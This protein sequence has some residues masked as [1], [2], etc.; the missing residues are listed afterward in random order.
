MGLGPLEPSRGIPISFEVDAV[1]V[2]SP[3]VPEGLRHVSR[4]EFEFAV[5]SWFR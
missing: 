5:S 4:S 3:E 2:R 1:R